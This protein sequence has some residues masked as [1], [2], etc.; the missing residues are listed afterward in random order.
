[1]EYWLSHYVI[2]MQFIYYIFA[3]VFLGNIKYW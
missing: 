2:L 1:M 3:I